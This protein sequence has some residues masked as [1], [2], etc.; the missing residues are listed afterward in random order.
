[1]LVIGYVS[2]GMH[3]GHDTCLSYCRRMSLYECWGDMAAS[4]QSFD[5]KEVYTLPLR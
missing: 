2:E 4:R 5:E 3:R 1:L